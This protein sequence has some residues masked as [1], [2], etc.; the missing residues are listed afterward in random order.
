MSESPD[1]KPIPDGYHTITPYLNV[2]G[3]A[4]ALAFYRKALGAEEVFRMEMP[5]GTVAHAEMRIGD[6]HFMVAEEMEDWG[7][8]SPGSLGGT[9]FSMMVYVEDCDAAFQRAIDAGATEVMP[10][11]D[12]FYGDRS[13]VVEDPYGHRWNLSTHVEDVPPDEMERRMKEMMAG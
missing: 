6:S 12:H 11:S 1:V 8:R 13:G 3:A 7:N 10:V 5:G 4:E 2:K 9:S